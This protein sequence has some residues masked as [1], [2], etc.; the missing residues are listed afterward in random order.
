MCVPITT[1]R[2]VPRDA[3]DAIWSLPVY[4]ERNPIGSLVTNTRTPTEEKLSA[5]MSK[6]SPLA[7]LGTAT[8]HRLEKIRPLL[9]LATCA[10]DDLHWLPVRQRILIK[11]CSL[12]SKC[13]RRAALC[14][15]IPVSV[16]T[17]LSCL[18]SAFIFTRWP[19]APALSTVTLWITLL[20]C[21]RSC[22]LELSRPASIWDLSS[23]SSCFCSHLKTK[24][25]F[26]RAYSMFVIA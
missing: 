19:V 6:S 1:Y 15:W 11:L 10:T 3:R 23:S 21:L 13:P 26:C 4:P 12:V 16:T 24:L 18:R 7:P 2:A 22:S 9:L 8:H 17:A 20:H 25:V 14:N 5:N